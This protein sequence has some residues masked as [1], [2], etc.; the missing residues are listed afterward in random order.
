VS[1]VVTN[2]VEWSKCG[3]LAVES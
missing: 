3:R 2:V 1:V